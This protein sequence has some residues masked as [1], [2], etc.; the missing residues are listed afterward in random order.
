LEDAAQQR[1]TLAVL[2]CEF[3]PMIMPSSDW[4]TDEALFASLPGGQELIDWFGF[5]PDFHDGELDAF[6]LRN[7]DGLLAIRTFTL[8]KDPDGFAVIDRRAVVT[9]RLHG[10]TGVK[11]EGNANSI[12]GA[13]VVR[14]LPATPE[15]SAWETCLGPVAGDIEIAFDTAFGL[16]GSIYAKELTFEL[17][18]CRRRVSS[19]RPANAGR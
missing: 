10:V 9:L 19:P 7:G 6:E 12:I 2:G 5:W 13:L 8:S 11:L 16:F 15:Q 3:F 4:T 14:R 18:P 1:L 17:R